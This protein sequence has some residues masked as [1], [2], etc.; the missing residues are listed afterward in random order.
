[1]IMQDQ[2]FYFQI[3]S[4]KKE[5]PS[6]RSLPCENQNRQ[7]TGCRSCMLTTCP[8]IT[9]VAAHCTWTWQTHFG[10]YSFKTFAPQS[11]QI[12]TL[13]LTVLIKYKTKIILSLI[14]VYK[15]ILQCTFQPQSGSVFTFWGGGVW[16]KDLR[17]CIMTI[18]QWCQ[19]P[20]SHS[21]QAQWTAAISFHPQPECCIYIL[22]LWMVPARDS[23]H[24]C[25]ETSAPSLPLGRHRL[26]PLH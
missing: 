22:V 26:Q 17:Q 19:L 3:L 14:L 11:T 24:S 4:F 21:A 20:D 8:R 7:G 10:K 2:Y 5:P 1:M 25:C 16:C 18:S 15:T 12:F 23:T 6:L 9:A 13:K